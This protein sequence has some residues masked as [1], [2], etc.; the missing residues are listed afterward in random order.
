MTIGNINLI[1]MPMRS[2]ELWEAIQDRIL[3]QKSIFLV[4]GAIITAKPL[5]MGKEFLKDSTSK[6]ALI[7]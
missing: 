1:D 6:K 2:L 3:R 5:C 7:D 4:I